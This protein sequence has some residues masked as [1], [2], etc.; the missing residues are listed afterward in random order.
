M[1]KG[2]AIA[3]PRKRCFV[4]APIEEEGSEARDHS[5]KV[6]KHLVKKTLEPGPFNY[7]VLR[8]D[9]D[10]RPGT[11]TSQVIKNIMDGDL[12]VADLT[13]RNA[14]VFYELTMCHVWQKPT[15]HLCRA[16]E[17]LPFDVGQLRVIFFAMGDPDSLDEARERIRKQVGWLEGGGKIETAIQFVQAVEAFRTGQ[18]KDEM[19]FELLSKIRSSLSSIQSEVG[20]TAKYVAAQ[21]QAERYEKL[22]GSKQGLLSSLLRPASLG[23]VFETPTPPKPSP[24]GK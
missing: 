15:I 18:A 10:E 11:I 8:A 17:R 13:G 19:M 6:L 4:I 22:F 5:D 21:R 1:R 9:Q 16:G 2:E 12:V 20:Y 3:A 7:D 14:N 23:E 24:K